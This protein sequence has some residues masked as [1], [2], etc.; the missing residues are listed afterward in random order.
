MCVIPYADKGVEVKWVQDIVCIH[1]DK[2]LIESDE[3]PGYATIYSTIGLIAYEEGVRVD[4]VIPNIVEEPR[5]MCN[6]IFQEDHW[7]T[8]FL[9]MINEECDQR[10]FGIDYENK[11]LDV[12]FSYD[13]KPS[14][15]KGSELQLDLIDDSLINV[16]FWPPS[17]TIEDTLKMNSKV[18]YAC[19]SVDNIN[20]GGFILRFG[21]TVK[22]SKRIINS[23]YYR[24]RGSEA[25]EYDINRAISKIKTEKH[26]EIFRDRITMLAKHRQNPQVDIYV[27]VKTEKKAY[28]YGKQVVESYSPD[29]VLTHEGADEHLPRGG[30][31]TLKFELEEANP[32]YTESPVKL[33]Y[34]VDNKFRIDVILNQTRCV[35][36]DELWKIHVKEVEIKRMK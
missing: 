12:K 9:N 23:D 25:A 4:F 14:T 17:D 21:Y 15:E 34:P 30:E 32:G 7:I 36:H 28:E 33:F 11:F 29:Y 10:E 6:T 3:D 18:P 1:P 20:R 27:F 16:T 22:K 35:F 19:Y 8:K 24:F 5:R 2:K 13:T 31:K 26:R